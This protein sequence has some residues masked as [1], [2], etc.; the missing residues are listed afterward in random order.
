MAK[1]IILAGAALNGQPVTV[2]GLPGTPLEGQSK[3][4]LAW[5][6]APAP[7]TNLTALGGR[8]AVFDEAITAPSAGKAVARADGKTTLDLRDTTS[9]M[10]ITALVN[11][12]PGQIEVSAKRMR[13]GFVDGEFYWLAQDGNGRFQPTP[14][15]SHRKVYVSGSPSAMTVAAI[16]A[17]AGVATSA[18]TGA[19]LRDRTQYGGSEAMPLAWDAFSLLRDALWGQGKEGRSDWCFFE[20]GYE[21]GDLRSPATKWIRGESE[22]HPLMF[23]AYGVGHWPK[24]NSIS[25]SVQNGEGPKNVIFRDLRTKS[26][27]FK[28]SSNLIIEG[29][30]YDGGDYL[31]FVEPQYLT[32]KDAR[33]VDHWTLAPKD[34]LYWTTADRVSASYISWGRDVIM[35]GCLVDQ[36]G[37]HLDYDI[38]ADPAKPLPH[39]DRNHN[40]YWSSDLR[41]VMIRDVIS[42]RGALTGFQMRCGSFTE[43]ALMLYNNIGYG[44]DPFD[45]ERENY[46]VLA[47]CVVMGSGNKRVNSPRLITGAVSV[48]LDV[49]S[50]DAVQIGCVVAHDADPAVPA[51]RAA[52]TERQAAFRG[53]EGGPVG[54]NY[55]GIYVDTQAFNWNGVDTGVQGIPGANLNAVSLANQTRALLSDPTADQ[56][57]FYAY[58]RLESTNIKA[59]CQQIIKTVKGPSAFNTPIPE[60][61]T[62]ADLVFLP[63]WRMEGMFWWNRRNW[64]DGTLPGTHVADTADLDGNFVRFGTLTTSIAALKSKGG[65]LDVTSGKL[66]I[67]AIT[68][69]ANIRVRGSGQIVVPATT[70]PLSIASEN[71]L[72]T[73][74]GAVT[75]LDMEV[76]GHAEVLLGLDATVPTGKKLV[77]SGQRALVGWDGAGSRT[78]TIAGTLEFRA[79]LMV[80]TSGSLLNPYLVT[81]DRIVTSN[82]S[83]NIADY[84]EINS[85]STNRLWLSDIEG[86]PVAGEAVVC[87]RAKSNFDKFEQ[88]TTTITT[89][90]SRGLPML[91][92]FRSGTIG[93]GLTDPTVTA[94]VTLAAGMQIVL[95]GLH[96]DPP[97]QDLTGLGINVIDNGAIKPEGVSVVPRGDGTNK[98]VYVKP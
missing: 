57:D 36:N 8:I 66:A 35:D 20:R 87:P 82:F 15:R 24:F 30:W 95:S 81:G 14:G 85:N 53:Q 70:Q 61:N 97:S 13:D 44:G 60:R 12:V 98:L 65:I 42:S 83:A 76:R 73:I 51:E 75:K 59:L 22:M 77:V 23:A 43:R 86:L 40:L 19:W 93:D 16:A 84:E 4:V 68:D 56:H 11:G 17:H 92:R 49:H 74:S 7:G 9:A 3:S 54:S 41:G 91:Q 78:L 47:D 6:E 52:R 33:L 21:Y 62:P 90:A 94:T 79:G 46:T 55:N 96:L 67:G 48:G 1:K 25:W 50:N 39:M 37:W 38:N 32:I 27:K 34:P 2:A 71:G 10:T 89:I 26:A 28:Y 5:G 18:V 72:T 31:E 64:S 69:A 80:T 45:R 29:G 88:K 63:D 58:A